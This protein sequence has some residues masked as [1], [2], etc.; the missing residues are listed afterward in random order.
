MKK[1]YHLSTC[2]T[3]QRIIK[4]LGIGDEFEYQD[5]KTEKITEA[6]IEEMKALAGSYESLF[7]RVARKYKE[8]GLKEKNLSEED[9]KQYI[10][11]E[12]TF[13]KR[14]VFI[15]DGQIFIGNSKKNVEA[16]ANALG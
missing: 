7:S 11:D 15:I 6:Q 13:L 9:Y 16:V 4:D 10:L 3:C 8:L 2:N 14:P 1:V 5:I 12:Y